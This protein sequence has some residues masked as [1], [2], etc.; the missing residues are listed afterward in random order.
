[1][2]GV[3]P[4]DLLRSGRSVAGL[5]VHAP[6]RVNLIGDHTDYTGGLVFPMAI[7]R[8]TTLVG[9]VDPDRI[10]LTSDDA[11]GTV[12]LALPVIEDP[13]AITPSWGTYVAAMARELGATSGVR[14]HLTSTIPAG[15]P[16]SSR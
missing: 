2:P 5:E 1:M 15:E 11:D 3:P 16:P 14:G 10:T 6:G 13:A 7:D 9:D 4:A 12:D 8:G